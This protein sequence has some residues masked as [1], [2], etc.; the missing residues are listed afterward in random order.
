MLVYCDVVVSP[1]HLRCIQ[2]LQKLQNTHYGECFY[3]RH[4]RYILIVYIRVLAGI[5]S[6]WAGEVLLRRSRYVDPTAV[7]IDNFEVV[8]D[9]VYLG[10]TINADNDFSLDPHSSWVYVPGST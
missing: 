7:R 2:S 5:G 1:E 4:Y 8:E 6:L 3:Y 9:F 10:S